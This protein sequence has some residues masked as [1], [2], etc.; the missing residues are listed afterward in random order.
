MAGVPVWSIMS[1]GFA[2]IGL[3]EVLFVW[4][5]KNEMEINATELLVVLERISQIFRSSLE[6][7]SSG[8][9]QVASRFPHIHSTS[10]TA[11][12]LSKH[13][14]FYRPTSQVLCVLFSQIPFNRSLAK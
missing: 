11:Y 2:A 8:V 14:Y 5:R 3:D 9:Q 6:G 7:D 1:E 12:P 4:K 10:H 13:I